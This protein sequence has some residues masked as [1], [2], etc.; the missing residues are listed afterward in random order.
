[1]TSSKRNDIITSKR[2]ARETALAAASTYDAVSHVSPDVKHVLLISGKPSPATEIVKRIG[3]GEWTATQVLEAY[4]ARAAH[5]QSTTNC[6]TE[7]LFEDARRQAT[8]LD[9]EYAA[10]KK[11]RG[12]LHGVPMSF[13]DQFEI[14]GYD[15]TTGFT[16]WSNQPCTENA[17]LV[18]QCRAAGAIIIA[19]TNV[20]QTMFAFECNNPLWGRTV[21]PWNDKYTCGGSSEAALLAMDGSALGVGSDIGGSLRIP[22]A[23]C[24]IYSLRPSVDRASGHGARG[25]RP[26]FEAVRVSYGPMA[27]SVEDCDLFCRTIFGE[28]DPSHRVVPVPYRPV[29]LPKK[30]KFGYY[31]SD[32][33]VRSS[34]ATVRAVQETVDALRKAGHECVEFSTPLPAN[35]MEVFVALVSSDGY[36]KMLSYL[37]DDPQEESLFLSTLGTKLPGFVRNLICWVV[38]TF[39]RDNVFPRF[40]SLAKTKTVL[41]FC[42]FTEKRNKVVDAWYKEVWD[43]H[44]FDGIIAPVQALPVIPHG[45]CAYLSGLAAATVLYNIIDS[46]TG[47]IPVTRVDANLDRLAADFKPG[48]TGGSTLFEKRMYQNGEQTVYKPDGMAGMPVGVQ[49]VGRRWDDEK[50]LAMMRVVDE[51]LG[52]RSFGPGSWEMRDKLVG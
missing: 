24:G 3:A 22:A 19:K 42:E 5:A 18:T 33:L 39:F 6:L 37:Q 26:G 9:Q 41:E 2:T 12:P 15:A 46:P 47:I 21:N 43:E 50:V 14:T 32:F 29:D 30:L 13:K 4:I 1:M 28:V 48:E 16:H 25:C 44:N 20:P 27:R 11:L 38:K 23:Y 36:R 8:E 40:F 52:P 31:F 49:I 34:P 45:A 51:A 7:I 17:F 35:A 10:T